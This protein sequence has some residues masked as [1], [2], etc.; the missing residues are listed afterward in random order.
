MTP[1]LRSA[2]GRAAVP[3]DETEG[4]REHGGA[5]EEEKHRSSS[6][7]HH[8]IHVLTVKTEQRPLWPVVVSQAKA[9]AETT[10]L[11]L[12]NIQP[13]KVFTSIC[14]DRSVLYFED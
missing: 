6:H 2:G 4:E 3:A 9:N 14:V 8:I 7:H 12:V 13:T 5:A 10:R 1:C 11:T